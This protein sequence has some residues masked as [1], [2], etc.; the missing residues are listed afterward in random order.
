MRATNTG[1]RRFLIPGAAIVGAILLMAAAM[2]SGAGVA[3][4]HGVSPAKLNQAGW[5]CDNIAP[6]GV[7]CFP[8]GS[9]ASSASISVLV[10]DTA[11]PGAMHAPFLGAEIL[12][13]AD[14]YH[15]QP[16][17]TD[18]LDEYHGLDLFGDSAIDYYACHFYDTSS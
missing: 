7:H 15:G 4:A 13:R 3:E 9:G 18:G 12:I 14:L 1:F 11:D 5:D 6:L 17:P 16:C 2:T 8:P 10:F